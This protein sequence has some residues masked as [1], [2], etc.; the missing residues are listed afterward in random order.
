MDN[1]DVVYSIEFRIEAPLVEKSRHTKGLN[2]FRAKIDKYSGIPE[3]CLL[4][5]QAM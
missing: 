3:I 1:L 4:I 2:D 5:L